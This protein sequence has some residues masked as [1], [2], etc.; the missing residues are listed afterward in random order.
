MTSPAQIISGTGTTGVSIDAFATVSGPTV[1]TFPAG[2]PVEE[3]H[4]AGEALGGQRDFRAS[5][6]G[7]IDGDTVSVRST[8]GALAV[9]P[10]FNAIGSYVVTWDGVDTS[11]SGLNSVGLGNEDLTLV[12]GIS[13]VG[14]GIQLADVQ[15]D[16]PGGIITLRVY[17]D[18]SNYSEATITSIA[19]FTPQ[20]FFI[21]FE[22]LL[23]GLGFTDVG[24]GATFSNVGAIELTF[25]ATQ[26]AMDGQMSLIGVIGNDIETANFANPAP[27]PS[28]DIEKL[29]NG[30]QADL[31]TDLNVPVVTPGSTVT[32]TYIVT[33]TGDADLNNVTVTDNPAG[34][35]TNVVS[36]WG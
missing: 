35:V 12:G 17:T 20:E 13:G 19:P 28:I 21:P 22:G 10:D 23:D 26:Q 5:L 11:G 27:M 14:A 29:T 16:Q 9:N 31:A 1:D 18:A 6:T 25:Q 30:N 15:V 3:V 4:S 2:T 32:W 24:S 34:V 33:N 7:G 36:R 8:G